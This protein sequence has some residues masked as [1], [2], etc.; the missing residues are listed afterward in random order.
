MPAPLADRDVP[1]P[2][3][4]H[5]DSCAPASEEF[6]SGVIVGHSGSGPLGLPPP[7]VDA[8]GDSRWLALSA[9]ARRLCRLLVALP[10]RLAGRSV[11][12]LDGSLLSAGPTRQRLGYNSRAQG[13][14]VG[15]RELERVLDGVELPELPLQLPA[16]VEAALV[17]S[18]IRIVLS[19]PSQRK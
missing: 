14:T 19:P 5:R 11:L 8:R 1:P 10:D 16:E 15:P 12:R 17:E 9:L 7:P 6:A 18:S 3:S 4:F 2:A 13:L